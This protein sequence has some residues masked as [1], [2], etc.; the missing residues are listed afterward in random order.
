MADLTEELMAELKE[1]FDLF[2]KGQTNRIKTSELPLV[3]RALNQ[4][5]TEAEL[6]EMIKEVDPDNTERISFSD[7]TALVTKRWKEVDPEEEL[8]E[9]FQVFDKDK[10][11][12]IQAAELKHM[13]M[14]MAEKFNEEEAEDLIKRANPDETGQIAYEPFIKLITRKFN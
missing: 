14:N 5:P 4:N 8:L 9:A 7:F 13:L 2:D 12:Y 10:T 1:A 3:I 6:E 11:G